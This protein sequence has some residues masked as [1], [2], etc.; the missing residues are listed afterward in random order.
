MWLRLQPV[1]CEDMAPSIA[2]KPVSLLHQ[3]ASLPFQLFNAAFSEIFRASTTACAKQLAFMHRSFSPRLADT[4]QRFR[5]EMSSRLCPTRLTEIKDFRGPP[6][7]LWHDSKGKSGVWSEV[8]GLW[9]CKAA[10]KCDFHRSHKVK[11]SI[12]STVL[13]KNQSLFTVRPTREK[14]KCQLL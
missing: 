9:A 7:G 3:R 4:S 11:R 5:K 13:Q 2:I 1:K 6:R 10:C 8:M 12:V 14:C